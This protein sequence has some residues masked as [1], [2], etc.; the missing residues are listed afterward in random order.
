VKPNPAEYN[1]IVEKLLQ[2]TRD[3]RVHWQVSTSSFGEVLY[4]TSEA[5]TCKVGSEDDGSVDF[6][7]RANRSNSVRSLTMKDSGG[8]EILAIGS[9]D[10]PT[11]A[12]EEE[13]SVMLDELYEL[14]RRQALKVEEKIELAS[15]LLDRV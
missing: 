11:S 2:K 7:I 5:F 8:N 14:A 10:L 13:V 12:E 3:G 6:I 4:D 9:N 15:A 1:P